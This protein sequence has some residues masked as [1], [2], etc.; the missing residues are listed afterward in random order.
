MDSCYIV[1]LCVLAV[2]VFIIVVIVRAWRRSDKR[3][4]AKEEERMRLEGEQA[5]SRMAEF[6]ELIE[7]VAR[8]GVRSVLESLLEIL[9]SENRDELCVAAV[10]AIG[11]RY[12][13]GQAPAFDVLLDLLKGAPGLCIRQRMRVTEIDNGQIFDRV[14]AEELREEAIRS[15]LASLATKKLGE[16]RDQRAVE[17]LLQQLLEHGTGEELYIRVVWALY[18][19]IKAGDDRAIQVL[20]GPIPP[21]AVENE[22]GQL[23]SFSQV[24]ALGLFGDART[25]E[26][27]VATAR[28]WSGEACNRE[29]RADGVPLYASSWDAVKAL[30]NILERDAANASEKALRSVLELHDL[31]SQSHPDSAQDTYQDMLEAVD[32]A[33]IHRLARQE[34][35]RRG[36][37]S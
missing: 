37:E 20:S 28:R 1:P 7:S 22:P 9:L 11:E 5:R 21:G 33:T 18:Q 30:E 3:D 23:L 17:P 35:Q 34:L 2:V 4:Y 32:C 14:D 15:R 13:S 27:F 25:V 10:E 24:Q 19:M 8:D 36:L 31:T 29:R 26:S 6:E 12:K 16:I